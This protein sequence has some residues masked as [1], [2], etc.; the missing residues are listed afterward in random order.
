M[1][2]TNPLL[3]NSST[4]EEIDV[5]VITT[6]YNEQQGSEWVSIKELCVTL[7]LDRTHLRRYARKLG[8]HF[9]QMRTPDSRNQLTLCLSRV[10]AERLYAMREEMGFNNSG[11]V[12][13][14]DVG[15]FYV[16]QVVPEL[17][18]GRVKL[19]FTEN[20]EK[21]LAEHRTSAPTAQ[22]LANWGCRRAWE[23]TVMDA[24]TS[25]GCA[26]I[27]NEVFQCDDLDDLVQRGDTLFELLPEPGQSTPLAPESPLNT[28]TLSVAAS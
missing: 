20:L 10:D 24:L 7:G 14:T 15:V 2:T 8:F 3:L 11:V 9:E 5:E 28:P 22:A 26:L 19:G 1:F 6:E 12:T 17:A 21:R 4:H 27:L 25:T 18:P 16:I 13:P 23:R